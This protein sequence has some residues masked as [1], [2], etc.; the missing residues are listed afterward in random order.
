M[1]YM[2][3]YRNVNFGAVNRAIRN[4]GRRARRSRQFRNPRSPYFRRGR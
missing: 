3:S 4:V 1:G 2:D